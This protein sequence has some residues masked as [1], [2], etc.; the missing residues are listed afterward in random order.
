MKKKVVSKPKPARK[1]KKKFYP[2]HPK[3]KT[4]ELHFICPYC[5]KSI[6]VSQTVGMM[7]HPVCKPC[8]QKVFKGDMDKYHAYVRATHWC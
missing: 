2:W 5:G 3:K 1:K 8:F 4:D 6:G 7:K